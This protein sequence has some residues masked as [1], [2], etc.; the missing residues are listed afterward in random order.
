MFNGMGTVA[1]KK[2]DSLPCLKRRKQEELS[3]ENP[4]RAEREPQTHQVTGRIYR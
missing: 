4:G 1:D 3:R 2:V